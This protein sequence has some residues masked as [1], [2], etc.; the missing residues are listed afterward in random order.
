[1]KSRVLPVALLLVLS[2]SSSAQT[3]RPVPA[4][5]RDAGVYH[6]ATDTWTRKASAASLGANVVY[7]NTCT[8][9]YYVALSGDTFV[10]EGRLP[11]PSSAAFPG[12]ATSYQIDGF[13]ISY[14][15]D[16]APATWSF[17]FFEQHQPCTSTVGV[18]PTAGFSVT[19]PGGSPASADPITSAGRSRRP[20]PARRPVR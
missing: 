9:G 17:G 14:C 4:R 6:V 8:T 1:M 13:T 7:D 20:R 5:P 19:L 11:S 12:C 3:A 18:Q 10:D 15:T 16:Q 2:A